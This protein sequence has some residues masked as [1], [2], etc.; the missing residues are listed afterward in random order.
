MPET[1]QNLTGC[2]QTITPSLEQLANQVAEL[3]ACMG[4]I[5]PFPNAGIDCFL[6]HFVFAIE[7]LEGEKA[8][9]FICVNMPVAIQTVARSNPFTYQGTGTPHELPIPTP[10]GCTLSQSISERDFMHFPQHF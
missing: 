10:P 4:D 5:S 9:H 3:R 2:E 6:S 1:I 7:F 8:G